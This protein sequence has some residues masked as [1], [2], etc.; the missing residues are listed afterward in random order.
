MARKIFESPTLS[1]PKNRK[2]E[3]LD[4]LWIRLRQR[5]RTLR[6]CEN[7][8]Y[9]VEQVGKGRPYSGRVGGTAMAG[10]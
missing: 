1:T 9:P 5:R 2:E 4:D 3:V 7:D 8:A 10:G 6:W